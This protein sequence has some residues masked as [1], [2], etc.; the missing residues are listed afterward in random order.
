MNWR[1]WINFIMS[2]VPTVLQIIDMIEQQ[3]GGGNGTVKKQIAL[4]TVESMAIASGATEFQTGL[5]MRIA[6][7][8]IDKQVAE[9]KKVEVKE[10][11][12]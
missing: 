10:N 5:A 12:G 11:N 2:L 6:G 4:N 1:Q 7:P 8:L 9:L 3:I